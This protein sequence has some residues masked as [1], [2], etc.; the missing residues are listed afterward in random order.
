MIIKVDDQRMAEGGEPWAL[1]LSGPGLGEQGFVR[2]EA[3]SL[4]RC[5]ER[6]IVGLRSSPGDWEWLMEFFN[7]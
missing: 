4:G 5:V 2:A 3:S 1:V 6:E 7:R